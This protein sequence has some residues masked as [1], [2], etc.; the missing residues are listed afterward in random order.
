MK[1]IKTIAFCLLLLVVFNSCKHDNFKDYVG[2][3]ICP[4]ASFKYKS[5]FKISASSIDFKSTFGDTISAS[6]TEPISW[7]VTITGK[8]SGGKKTYKAH[9]DTIGI[10][11]QGEPGDPDNTGMY[12]FFQTGEDV[13]VELTMPC[14]E[15]VVKTIHIT[16]A[17]DFS[18]LGKLVSDFEGNGYVP[19][20]TAWGYSANGFSSYFS[21][22]NK[23]LE[24]GI[25]TSPLEGPA[26]PHYITLK[27]QAGPTSWYAGSMEFN[28]PTLM[29]ASNPD[30]VYFN[31]FM[32]SGDNT[33]TV[34]GIT[35]VTNKNYN[36]SILVNWKGWK[37]LAL[38]MSDFKDA[39][40]NSMTDA[41]KLSRISLGLNPAT[42]Q[43]Q[44][45]EV[46]LDFIMFTKNYPFFH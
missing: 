44:T 11:W 34:V 10:I 46:D 12:R 30:S 42:A 24:F 28:A 2:P 5:D 14:Q 38:K 13:S 22:P 21:A 23:E 9:S 45:C 39:Q 33:T 31:V 43:G 1:Y 19:N 7:T 32:S 3:S 18:L 26:G 16:G 35:M 20:N 17:S 41:T 29:P 36:K 4:S 8:T 40:G 6:F 25:V 15:T 27:G 37:M